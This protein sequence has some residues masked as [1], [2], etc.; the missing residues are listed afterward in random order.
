MYA[1]CRLQT[2]SWNERWPLSSWDRSV[3]V[4]CRRWFDVSLDGS[5]QLTGST[6]RAK[7]ITERRP[8]GTR[9]LHAIRR[10]DRPS[11]RCD[12]CLSRSR[13]WPPGP[14][15]PCLLHVDSCTAK[16][17]RDTL[18]S[19][20]AADSRQVILGSRELSTW[21]GQCYNDTHLSRASCEA[22]AVLPVNFLNE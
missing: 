1:V 5:V 2:S 17:R 4:S 6:G 15:Q 20:V 22:K 3:D 10:T 16:R 21:T 8:P 19:A 14:F 12:V 18:K 13:R 9:S 7:R 11:T